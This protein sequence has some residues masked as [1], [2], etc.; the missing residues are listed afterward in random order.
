M[1]YRATARTES[2]KAEIH[3]RIL[4]QARL[5]VANEGFRGLSIAAVATLSNIATGTIYRYFA[6]KAELCVAVFELAI[7]HEIR[8]VV[9][10]S[11]QG[12]E[13]PQQLKLGLSTFASRALSNPTLAYALIAEP[14]DPELEQTRLQYRALWA[15]TFARILQRGMEMGQFHV[16]PPHLTAAALVGA[17]AES[18]VI[19]SSPLST[20]TSMTELTRTERCNH[21]VEFCLRA[22][23][24]PEVQP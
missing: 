10:A 3:A 14:V 11:E 24:K 23:V 18:I 6:S 17:M 4:Q 5:L 21:I 13:A 12:D 15:E 2:R 22:V 8:A 9:E 7:E 16:Q 1:A 20:A 19:A